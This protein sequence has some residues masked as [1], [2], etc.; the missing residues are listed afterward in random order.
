VEQGIPESSL[1]QAAYGVDLSH[2]RP[3][4]RP[5]EGPFR[6]LFCGAASL[7]KGVHYLLQAFCELNLPGSELWLIG[8][9]LDELRPFL[10]RWKHPGIRLLGGQAQNELYRLYQQGSVF[11][12]PSIEDGFA[13]VLL[14]AMACGLPVICTTNSAGTDLVQDGTEGYVIPIRD[15]GALKDRLATLAADEALRHRMGTAALQRV[16]QGF[17]WDDYGDR[18]AAAYEAALRKKRGS[19]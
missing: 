2:F 11:C 16:R 18:I 12:L 17:T 8:S 5:N 19:G 6:V 7:R 13:M 1:I 10:D 14:Q 4:D 3:A 9:V 15:P